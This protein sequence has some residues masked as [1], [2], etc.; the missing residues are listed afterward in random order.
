MGLR[1]EDGVPVTRGG[2]PNMLRHPVSPKEVLLSGCFLTCS[3][4]AK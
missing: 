2:G 1:S 4:L 3:G